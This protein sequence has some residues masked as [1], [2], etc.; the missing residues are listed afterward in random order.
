MEDQGLPEHEIEVT[1]GPEAASSARA[2]IAQ[3]G[4]S[5]LRERMDDLH[6][7]ISELV[8]NAVRHGDLR[9]D[10]DVVRIIVGAGQDSV[11][12]TVE[13]PTIAYGVTIGDVRLAEDDPGGFG[14]RLV[15]RL[16]DGWG[17]DPGPPGRVW[18]EFGGP[19]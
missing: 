18:F 8:T 7:A 12:V 9:W 14:L 15:D 2:A 10:V 4:I 1:A 16:A 17:H 3:L 11:R 6:L 5:Q 13:Q 19:F